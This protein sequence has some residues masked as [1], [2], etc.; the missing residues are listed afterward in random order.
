MSTNESNKI[1]VDHVKHFL[2]LLFLVFLA[3]N[4][5][6]ENTKNSF[7]SNS[8]VEDAFAKIDNKNKSLFTKE[9]RLKSYQKT[10]SLSEKNKKSL[11][12]TTYNGYGAA[13]KQKSLKRSKEKPQN[14][15]KKNYTY[16]RNSNQHITSTYA[17]N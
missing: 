14:K 9:E 16:K 1:L 11:N 3:F 6:Q 10:I 17:T 15:K 12:K 5:C 8:D 13:S 2:G 4:S 7:T